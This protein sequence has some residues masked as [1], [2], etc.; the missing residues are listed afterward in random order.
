[1]A[2]PTKFS[3]AHKA[4]L[5]SL[6][7]EKKQFFTIGDIS[8]LF[9]EKRENWDVASSMTLDDF[10]N[11]L[12]INNDLEEVKLKFPNKTISNYSIGSGNIPI[13]TL[14]LS[15]KNNSYLSHYTALS[16][17]NLTEQIPKTIYVTSERKH[18]G[19]NENILA[20]E[21]IDIAF[22]KEQ[23]VSSNYAIF[24]DY[25][26]YLLEGQ[27][28]NNK[29]VLETIGSD[30]YTIRV[31]DIERTLIDIVVRPN[32]AGGIYEVLKAYERA[33]SK[34]SINRLAAYLSQMK[35]IYPYAQ[36][37]GFY[38]ERSGAYRESQ[39][40]LLKKKFDF[41]FYLT[42]SMKDTEYSEKWRLYYP[43]GF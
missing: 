36:A 16:Y 10:I 8:T 43:K 12:I 40:K 42:Y 25:T 4:I 14:A 15:I 38:M 5:K 33:A 29:G 27:S 3:I 13:N 9:Y 6:K 17:H 20:Q 22:S 32:Y 23:R 28:T 37:I 24:N 41:N 2:R 21:S 11:N 1:M 35:F 39:I 19:E 26:I 7:K 30:G 31:T 34:V 18:K